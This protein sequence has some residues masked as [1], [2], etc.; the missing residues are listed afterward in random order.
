MMAR[1]AR[2]RINFLS[3]VIALVGSMILV[4]MQMPSAYI[5]FATSIVWF[6]LAASKRRSSS[7]VKFPGRRI[8]RR[9]SRLLLFS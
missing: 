9:F 7:M 3:A 1:M 4:I 8:A 2:S 5:W 6:L